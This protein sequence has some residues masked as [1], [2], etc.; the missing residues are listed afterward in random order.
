MTRQ[1]SNIVQ[2]SGTVRPVE[3]GKDISSLL[4]NLLICATPHGFEYLL[5]PVIKGALRGDHSK[6]ISYFGKDKIGNVYVS[7]GKRKEY[8]T[9]FSCHIDTMHPAASQ[10]DL[11]K[12]LTPVITDT[13]LGAGKS[14][15]M[16][17]GAYTYFSK[18]S[19]CELLMPSVLG[20][21]DKLGAY[22][23]LRMIQAGIKGLY[24]F[25]VGEERG[26]IG[27]KHSSTKNASFF[28]GLERCIAWDRAGYG[29][30][31]VSQRGGRCASDK[32][33]EDFA[34]ALNKSLT[35]KPIFKGKVVGVYT[36]SANYTSIIP[37]CTNI[38]VAYWN[39][40]G[41]DEHFDA[42]WL[43]RMLLP[44]ILKIDYE[45]LP[46]V[47]KTT[48]TS[49]SNYSSS[50]SSSYGRKKPEEVT[51]N[52]SLFDCPDWEIK[53]GVLPGISRDAMIRIISANMNREYTTPKMATALYDLLAGASKNNIVKFK[54]K[55]ARRDTSA[56][57]VELPSQVN[58]ALA[59]L[60]LEEQQERSKITR[61]MILLL[62]EVETLSKIVMRTPKI[63][64]S[65]H[66][67]EVA[68]ARLAI[69]TC[70]SDQLK[71][72]RLPTL[73]DLLEVSQLLV[74]Y[75]CALSHVGCIEKNDKKTIGKI[76]E[77]YDDVGE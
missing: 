48:D 35:C 30:V 54:G 56:P 77:A 40:H 9:M 61:A 57:I 50:Y 18:K 37:E 70:I 25:H 6:H 52:T 74:S 53:D 31:I 65:P 11:P 8:K 23:M 28:K 71:S 59:Q 26:C 55:K 45:A 27:S 1:M 44:A 24:V 14:D 10:S 13:K 42:I 51:S 33:T 36:D 49:Y 41:S 4:H 72:K 22:L 7:V 64:H 3:V 15:G 73:E 12:V 5:D 2:T 66:N 68:K 19:Q 69:E 39:Q 67:L 20:A 34:D 46:T 63:T 17:Y 32:F 43:E 76:I 60:T 38:S 58:A 47:R 29:D 75:A 21:D 62:S 16:V